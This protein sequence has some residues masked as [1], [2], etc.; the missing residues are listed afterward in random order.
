MRFLHDITDLWSEFQM[1]KTDQVGQG[2]KVF[3][4]CP[5]DILVFFSDATRRKVSV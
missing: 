2:F 1:M 3:T 4:I 5:V